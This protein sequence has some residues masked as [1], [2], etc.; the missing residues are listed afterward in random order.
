MAE[1]Q[2][3]LILTKIVWVA[4]LS[5]FVIGIFQLSNSSIQDHQPKEIDNQ[6]NTPK[7]TAS[8]NT[9]QYFHG[10]LC[11]DDCSGHQAGYDWA[12]ENDITDPGDCD[13]NSTSFI[14]GCEA[15]ANE[16]GMDEEYPDDYGYPEY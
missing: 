5:I 2:S 16:I 12:M 3:P 4:V 8:E 13:G 7:P 10:D 6:I 9:P 14:E 15:Y 1:L 11:T